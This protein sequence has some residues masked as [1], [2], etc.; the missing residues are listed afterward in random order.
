MASAPTWVQRFEIKHTDSSDAAA[1]FS[2][3]KYC[4]GCFTHNKRI[5]K[6]FLLFRIVDQ[7]ELKGLCNAEKKK[8]GDGAPFASRP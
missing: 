2:M 7:L 6:N 3:Y 1:I 4:T 5:L 8:N